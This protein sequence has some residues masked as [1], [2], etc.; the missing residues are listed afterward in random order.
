MFVAK[1]YYHMVTGR[2]SVCPSFFCFLAT[3][4]HSCLNLKEMLFFFADGDELKN[5]FA[6]YTVALPF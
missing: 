4:R 3:V 1:L 5:C 6:L 2:A